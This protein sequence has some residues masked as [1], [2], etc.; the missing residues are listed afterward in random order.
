MLFFMSN[1]PSA[2]FHHLTTVVNCAKNSCQG[3]RETEIK[4]E[5]VGIVY[6]LGHFCPSFFQATDG[7]SVL[8]HPGATLA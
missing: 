2:T 4:R 5:K 7:N 1:G 6:A 8:K 3:E